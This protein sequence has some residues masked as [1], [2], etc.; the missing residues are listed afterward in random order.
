[1]VSLS[2][3]VGETNFP[4]AKG[5]GFKTTIYALFFFFFF[6]ISQSKLN[7]WENISVRTERLARLISIK[8]IIMFYLVA[9]MKEVYWYRRDEKC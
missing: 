7:F 5:A 9:I 1:M 4:Q 8:K 3:I 2:G 6:W